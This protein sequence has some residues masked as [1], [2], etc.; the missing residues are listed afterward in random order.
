LLGTHEMTDTP[1]TSTRART[2]V[3]SELGILPRRRVGLPWIAPRRRILLLVIVK[4]L[5]QAREHVSGSLKHRPGPR[6]RDQAHIRAQTTGQ[7]AYLLLE[8]LRVVESG[9]GGGNAH[10]SSPRRHAGVARSVFCTAESTQ[11]VD[12]ETD[13]KNQSNSAAAVAGAANVEAAAAEQ[14]YQNDYQEEWVHGR[15]ITCRYYRSNGAL[16]HRRGGRSS[17]SVPSWP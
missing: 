8:L 16:T 15:T 13:Q 1:A 14:E 6:F 7:G 11:K 4:R 3:V 2:G 9:G 10:A 5:D 17:L 12:Y